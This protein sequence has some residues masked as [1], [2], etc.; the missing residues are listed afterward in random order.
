M[1]ATEGGQRG[2]KTL[3]FECLDEMKN[4]CLK[5]LF[6]HL[7]HIFLFAVKGSLL[8]DLATPVAPLAGVAAL[9]LTA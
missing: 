2:K 6:Q 9:Y 4:M 3:N 1:F 7:K 5:V 8:V